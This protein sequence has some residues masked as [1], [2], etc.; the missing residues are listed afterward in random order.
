MKLQQNSK[1]DFRQ[2]KSGVS[3]QAHKASVPKIPRSP[4]AFIHKSKEHNNSSV[5]FIELNEN[6][7]ETDKTADNA[8]EKRDDSINDQSYINE[9][10]V[11]N[12][13]SS[14]SPLTNT[15]QK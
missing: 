3:L 12:E 4:R 14:L 10:F 15:G 8:E 11:E 9:S 1:S 5:N 2:T 6:Y 7:K 13:A